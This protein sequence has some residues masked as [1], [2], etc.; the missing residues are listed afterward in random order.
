MSLFCLQTTYR[1]TKG[2]NIL[3]GSILQTIPALALLT[4]I[5]ATGS[6]GAYL[7]SRTL[8]PLIAVLFPKP[9]SLVR[10]ALAPN[11]TP[12]ASTTTTSMHDRVTPIAIVP[13]QTISGS[14]VWRRLL[15]MR[16][17]GF[18]P[19]SG[20]NVACGVVGVDWK[21]FWLTTAAGS[22]S[23]SYVTASVS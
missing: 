4:F 3:V 6:L 12:Q 20:M 17:G 7:L 15:V 13:T 18:V 14:Q 11:S 22:A 23:W 2:Q 16:A 9:L 10:A 19:W 1:L 5:T 21:V 8:A